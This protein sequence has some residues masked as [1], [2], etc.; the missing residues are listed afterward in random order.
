MSLLPCKAPGAAVPPSVRSSAS[1]QQCRGSGS[2]SKLFFPA[3][4]TGVSLALIFTPSVLLGKHAIQRTEAK[5]N[6]GI[7]STLISTFYLK[8]TSNNLV[9]KLLKYNAV[10]YL[11]YNTNSTYDFELH[12][13]L[14]GRLAPSSEVWRNQT[15]NQAEGVSSAHWWELIT[16]GN[17]TS[18][19]MSADKQR[20]EKGE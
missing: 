10:Y 18:L 16:G 12:L 9:V 6:R 2:S 4:F 17:K 1:S 15:I 19:E 3:F 5:I 11:K 8:S 7:P 20:L 14:S 13:F